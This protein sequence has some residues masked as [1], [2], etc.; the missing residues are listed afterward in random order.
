MSISPQSCQ[1][2]S[3]FKKK[4][5]R[6][7]SH[8]DMLLLL[9]CFG[10]VRLCE[11]PQAAAHQAPPSLEFSRQEH[12]SGLPFPSPHS[13]M[14]EMVSLC[15]FDIHFSDDWQCQAFFHIPIG[16][17]YVF[18]EMSIQALGQFFNWVIRFGVFFSWVAG[19]P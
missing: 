12:W 16:H 4:K 13:D 5:K 10:H 8:S 14:C 18:R 1:H 11:T 17:L 15:G 9:S 7:T 2:L 3:V 6:K 19:V